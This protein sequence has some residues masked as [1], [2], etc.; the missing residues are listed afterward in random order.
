M[1]IKIKSTIELTPNIE[2]SIEKKFASIAKLVKHFETSG[3][4]EI[5]L[6][7]GRSKHHNKGEVFTA[8]ADLNVPGKNIHAEGSG[9]DL[10]QAVD[11][12]RDV[13]RAEMERFK[14]KLEPKRGKE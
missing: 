2:A 13:V 9:E 11:S 12:V 10:M 14:D 1:Q 4:M 6:E 3:E 8:S 5:W 7:L